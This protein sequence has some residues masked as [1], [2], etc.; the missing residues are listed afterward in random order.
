MSLTLYYLRQRAS[1]L[2]EI[3]DCGRIHLLFTGAIA[4]NKCAWLS[5]MAFWAMLRYARK[6]SGLP[7]KS[8]Y[9]E[10]E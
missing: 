3:V 2:M 4:G 8:S 9:E 10:A 6:L 7:G 5:P 1:S